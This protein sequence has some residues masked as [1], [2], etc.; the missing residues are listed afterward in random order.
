MGASCMRFSP[1][2]SHLAIG[3]KNGS[4][5]VMAVETD[6]GAGVDGDGRGDGDEARRTELDGAEDPRGRRGTH[7]TDQRD[8][9]GGGGV[10]EEGEEKGD[11]DASSG[12][13]GGGESGIDSFASSSQ[14]RRRRGREGPRRVYRRIAHF[15][16]HSSRVLHLDWTVDGRFVH[17]CGQDDHILHWEILPPPPH[18]RGEGAGDEASSD[19]DP[20][21]EGDDAEAVAGEFRPRMF[22]RA[23]LVRDEQ[24]ETWSSTIGWPVQ[25][26][27]VLHFWLRELRVYISIEHPRCPHSFVESLVSMKSHQNGLLSQQG[28]RGLC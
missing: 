1:S 7:G 24:W 22:K 23:F 15:K 17:T 27:G 26:R 18:G 5:V 14:R 9:E 10:G 20:N 2:G 12:G 8:G 19:D 3:C 13:R 21:G 28:G 11:G 16:G 4:L 25:V 6:G